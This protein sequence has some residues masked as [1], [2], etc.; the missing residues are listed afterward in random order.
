M[1]VIHSN[2]KVF[3]YKVQILQAQSQVNKNQL[4]ECYQ[5][6]SEWVENKPRLLDVLLLSDKAHFHL[7]DHGNKQNITFW[8]S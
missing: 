3:P 7:S 6:T 8:T 2:L 1:K 4:Y 5:S